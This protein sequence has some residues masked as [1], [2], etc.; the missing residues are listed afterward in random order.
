M[1]KSYNVRFCYSVAPSKFVRMNPFKFKYVGEAYIL[2]WVLGIFAYIYSSEVAS[3]ISHIFGSGSE[4]FWTM[5]QAIIVGITLLFIYF[6]LKAQHSKNMLDT[7]AVF[8]D[9]W[10]SKEMRNSRKKLCQKYTQNDFAHFYDLEGHALDFFE[11]M[12]LYLKKGVY[13]R[14]VIWEFYSYYIIYYWR[15]AQNLIE[16]YR[17]DERD[18]TYYVWFEYLYEEMLKEYENREVEYKPLNRI[19]IEKFIKDEIKSTET[20]EAPF[21][22]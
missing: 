5:A 8:D 1:L 13:N 20:I 4:W 17:K 9:R 16:Q 19:Q 15:I 21:P 6:Q 22:E 2:I 10:N 18:N 12:G 14:D 7:I 3:V 11:Q